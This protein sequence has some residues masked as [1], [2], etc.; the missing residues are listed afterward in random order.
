MS[1]RWA[2]EITS[3]L[4]GDDRK[5][6][7]IYNGVDLDHFRPQIDVV[8]FRRRHK[9]GNDK[10]L[11][12]IGTFSSQYDFDECCQSQNI[13]INTKACRSCSWDRAARMASCA[14]RSKVSAD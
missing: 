3:Y 13:S 7:V 9:L 11:S 12:F 4:R 6:S 10:V 1:P 8:D 5:V 14:T 2:E